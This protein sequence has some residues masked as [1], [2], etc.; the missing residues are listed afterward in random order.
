MAHLRRS[1]DAVTSLVDF[2]G[3]KDKGD[4]SAEQLEQA[5]LDAIEN[6]IGWQDD[7]AKPYVQVHEFEGLLFSDVEAFCT[8]LGLPAS[9]IDAL[10]EIRS[11][12]PSPEHINDNV[13]T[14]PSHRL[15]C[16][17]PGYRKA[18]HGPLIADQIGLDTIR[19]ECLRFDSW[20]ERLESLSEAWPASIRV[21]TG[22]LV[23][24]RPSRPLLQYV[25]LPDDS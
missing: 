19:T 2:Y 13:N 9:V 16:E 8:L 7:S 3:F 1:F 17:V 14:S 23:L 21:L 10:R 15:V 25:A 5:V 24:C 6:R 22:D 11:N 20:I 4:R 12:F 18:V